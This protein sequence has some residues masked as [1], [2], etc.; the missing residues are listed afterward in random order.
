[1]AR[2]ALQR[3]ALVLLAEDQTAWRQLLARALTDAGHHVVEV[4]DGGALGGVLVQML[5]EAGELPDV[6]ISDLRMPG[7]S[8]LSALQQLRHDDDLTPFVL[9]T[10]FPDN[11]LFLTAARL[12]ATTVLAKPFEP[13]ELV[14]LVARLTGPGF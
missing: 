6:I 13:R 8:G 9:M 14:A 5:G 4:T 7:R 1:M 2:A 11:E 12:G 10:A 3:M